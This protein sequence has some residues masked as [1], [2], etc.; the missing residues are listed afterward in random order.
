MPEI[1]AQRFGQ[2]VRDLE[3]ALSGRS[4]AVNADSELHYLVTE[5]KEFVTGTRDLAAAA[6]DSETDEIAVTVGYPLLVFWHLADAIALLLTARVPKLQETLRTV[7]SLRHGDA[8]QEE[9]FYDAAYE[10][11]S[12]ADFCREGLRPSF[13]DTGQRS[14]YQKRV[15]YLLK[16]KW[17]VE[18]KRPRS[19]D[20]I[21]RLAGD[22]RR[23]IDERGT[24][25]VVCICL[26][27]AFTD[28]VSF[29]EYATVRDLQ[30]DAS[31]ALQ[32]YLD[33]AKDGLLKAA[34]SDHS[35]AVVFHM[36][37]LGYVHDTECISGPLLRCALTGSGCVLSQNV[38][39][40][41][42]ML[43]RDSGPAEDGAC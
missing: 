6:T 3:M 7:A 25:G 20:G 36:E 32:N 42:E 19:P 21:V 38:V 31:T 28:R 16:H 40:G 17:S 43:L 33:N 9:Q 13:I 30:I 1:S 4:I 5:V 29:R 15:E 27:H 18:C 39:Q 10:L 35:V 8:D 37:L 34:T 22:A 26:D 24:R 23:K 14:R 12:A 2:L 41:L 11:V